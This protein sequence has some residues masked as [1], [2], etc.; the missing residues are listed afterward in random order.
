M[1]ET[2]KKVMVIGHKNPDSD[3][4][5]SAIAYAGLMNAVREKNIREGMKDCGREYEACRAGV[6]NKETEFVLR[7]FG[8]QIPR[9]C[10]DVRAQVSDLD[11]RDELGI[12]SSTSLRNA[13]RMMIEH[14]ITTLPVIHHDGQLE[15]IITVQD[16]AMANMDSLEAD[17]LSKAKV[18]LRNLLETIDGE[19]PLE[20]I[21]FTQPGMRYSQVQALVFSLMKDETFSGLDA[22]EKNMVTNRILEEVRGRMME[23]IV[24]LETKKKADRKKSV[25]KLQFVSGEYDM[26]I[27][28]QESISCSIYEVKHSR[29]TVPAQYR[30]LADE[31]KCQQTEQR[32]GPITEKMV[33]FRGE[34]KIFEGIQYKNVEEYLEQL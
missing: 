2:T 28:D 15:G 7:R 23:E 22:V 18:P 16:I 12:P 1:K 27:A 8:F 34:T 14:D 26:V 17:V 33:I 30:F 3:S 5:C 24:L 4:I 11:I 25:F 10:L 21:I 6:I 9:L 32:Y 29:E 20:H 31:E 19:K 13:W